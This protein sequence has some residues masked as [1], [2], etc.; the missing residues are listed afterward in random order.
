MTTASMTLAETGPSDDELVRAARSDRAGFAPIYDRY[1]LPVYRFLR[2]LGATDDQA[3]DVTATTFERA[4][5]GIGGY[6]GGTGGLGAWLCRIARNTYLN[7]RKRDR[8][9]EPLDVVAATAADAGAPPDGAELRAM[10]A[11]LPHATRD[12][13]VL[14]Y[15]AGLTTKEIGHV[16]GRRPDAVQKLIERGLA[17]LKEAYR[18]RP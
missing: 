10:V 16:L 2:A 8:R 7:E 3:A 4:I 14:R 17:T 9:L 11:G 1:Q 12:A 5:R 18:D 13:I 6:R 15:A